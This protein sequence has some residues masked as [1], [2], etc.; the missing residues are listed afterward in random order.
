MERNAV[1]KAT[2]TEKRCQGLNKKEWASVVGLCQ[3]KKTLT[4][5]SP[6]RDGE[7]AGLS[8]HFLR[9]GSGRLVA[10]RKRHGSSDVK[11]RVHKKYE[12]SARVHCASFFF[13]FWGGGV[14]FF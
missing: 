9:C 6:S 8:V 13:F 12:R 1:E 4:A 14:I 10:G 7:P 5:S 11:N 3:K 2:K